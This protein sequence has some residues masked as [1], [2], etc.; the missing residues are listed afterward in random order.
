MARGAGESLAPSGWGRARQ[1]SSAAA[2]APDARGLGPLRAGE[3]VGGAEVPD[4][5]G[6]GHCALRGA[7]IPAWERARTRPDQ[8]AGVALRPQWV[9]GTQLGQGR[10]QRGGGR[11]ARAGKSTRPTAVPACRPPHPAPGPEGVSGDV[12]GGDYSLVRA[13]VPLPLPLPLT[14]RAGGGRRLPGD[15]PELR[16]QLRSPRP[17]HT[18]RAPPVAKFGSTLTWA[19]T[20]CPFHLPPGPRRPR[21]TRRRLQRNPGAPHGGRRRQRRGDAARPRGGVGPRPPVGAD[22]VSGCRVLLRDPA[23]G[24]NRLSPPGS[25]G[26]ALAPEGARTSAGRIETALPLIRPRGACVP[27]ACGRQAGRKSGFCSEGGGGAALGTEPSLFMCL[28][29]FT[30]FSRRPQGASLIRTPRL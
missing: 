15:R 22:G 1:S 21:R 29:A 30:F 27:S 3:G 26:S 20:P 23:G 18:P 17:A 14:G 2:S 24:P 7:G 10:R 11:S 25:R 6:L 16:C 5:A 4:A 19:L 9:G 8:P 13:V 12:S 28:P